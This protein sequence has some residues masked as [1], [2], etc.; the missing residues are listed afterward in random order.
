MLQEVL[1]CDVC[2]AHYGR[3]ITKH[4]PKLLKD[5]P[6]AQLNTWVRTFLWRLHNEINDENNKYTF[7]Y[8][9]LS[10]TYKGMDITK[11]WKQLEPVMLKAI[12]LNG[13]TLFPWKKWLGHVRMLQGM[14][15]I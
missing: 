11:T 3:W 10:E 4:K 13:L 15:G 5:L 1:P 12:T 14:Y 2:Q 9:S 7:P 6:Y 8:T